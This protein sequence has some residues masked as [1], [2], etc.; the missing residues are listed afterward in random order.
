MPRPVA[1]GSVPED[2]ERCPKYRPHEAKFVITLSDEIGLVLEDV[3]I[4][5]CCLYNHLY[6]KSGKSILSSDE[7]DE[8]AL[9]KRVYKECHRLPSGG[10]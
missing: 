6:L 2:C 4:C 10:G 3:S 1:M 5:P 7:E 8:K 9:L